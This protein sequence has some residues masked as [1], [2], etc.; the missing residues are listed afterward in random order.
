MG[1]L[2]VWAELTQLSEAIKPVVALW[3]EDGEVGRPI[4]DLVKEVPARVDAY[5]CNMAKSCIKRVLGGIR[6]LHPG[7]DLAPVAAGPPTY[8][9]DERLTQAE[10]EV[11]QVATSFAG[12]LEFV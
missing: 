3:A 6:V 11:D 1:E 9:S 4:V 10:E 2:F 8:C 5:I 12:Q 7:T